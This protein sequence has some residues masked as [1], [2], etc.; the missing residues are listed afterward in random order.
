M[1]Q[2]TKADIETALDDFG[3]L[4]YWPSDP[5]TRAAIGELLAKMVPSY[6]ALCYLRDELVNHIGEWPGPVGLRRTLEAKYKP[7]DGISADLPSAEE[8]YLYGERRQLTSA[9]RLLA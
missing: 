9:R 3:M 6:A 7:A 8:R 1:S 2:F 4:R 5:G